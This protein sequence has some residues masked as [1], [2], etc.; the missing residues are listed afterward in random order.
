MVQGNCL[1]LRFRIYLHIKNE[2]TMGS[3]FLF[4]EIKSKS[5]PFTCYKYLV[6]IILIWCTRQDLNLQ[7]SESESDAL[8]SCATGAKSATLANKSGS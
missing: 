4:R 5:E 2:P 7:P 8:S 3:F 6:R 1:V